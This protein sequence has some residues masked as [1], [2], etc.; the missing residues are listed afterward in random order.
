MMKK[1]TEFKKV[2]TVSPANIA[3][4]KYWGRK[5]HDS[6]IPYNDNISMTMDG[7]LTTTT[8]EA[9]DDIA[10]DEIEIKFFGKKYEKMSRD[11][12]KRR[13]L[14]DQIDRIRNLAGSK[15]K[16]KMKSVNNFPADA[17]IAASASSFSTATMA[18]LMVFGLNELCEDKEELSRQIRLCGSGSAVR[19][20]YGG[21]VEF[22]AGS[23]HKSSYATQIADENHWDLVDIVAIV[24]PEKK[25]TSSSQGHMLA[26]TSPYYK[27]RLKEMKGRI[28]GVREGI[29]KKDIKRLGPLIE[30]DSTS[31]HLVMM[32]S[33]PPIYYWGP[34]SMRIMQDIIKW[35]EEE[36]LLS[37][38]T[39]DAG[40]NV[41]VICEEKDADRVE[42]KLKKNEFVKWT[43]RN[44]P[45]AGARIVD[46]HLF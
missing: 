9:R 23:S 34:G 7:C 16:I 21:F 45:C 4:I 31:M 35:R 12:I 37:Y 8:I 30:E 15:K 27:A 2:T 10:D 39:L 36:G 29:L 11:T 18:L 19:S 25:H 13:N 42:R 3:F 43:I 20:A 33:K 32:T 44:R 6:F 17:G 5:D 26:D 28:K 24:D 38:F 41:H 22:L 14:Y 40:P 1:A 46:E